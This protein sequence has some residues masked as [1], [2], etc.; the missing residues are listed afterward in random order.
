MRINRYMK[1]FFLIF[2]F[3]FLFNFPAIS[4]TLEGNAEFDWIN[5]K[6]V[7]RDEQIAKIHS[8]IFNENL[9]SKY[10]KKD[11]QK[12]YENFLKDRNFKQTRQLIKD[13]KKETQDKIITAFF[14]KKILYAYGIIYK[15]DLYHC[16]YY[17]ALGNIFNIEVFEKPYNE[18]P[19][20]SKQYDK[21]GKLNAVIYKKGEAD[22]FVYNSRGNF[23]GRW[24]IN[25]YY[26][27]NG[28]IIMTRSSE[29]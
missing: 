7:Q 17:D 21:N 2:I 22:E 8:E 19:L 14:A 25:N 29:F 13:G 28:K 4:L 18:Y 12:Q 5:L 16:Y 1:K 23:L 9:I 10:D 20:V 15:S 11:F 27:R 6:Q 26:N 24:Y 3:I